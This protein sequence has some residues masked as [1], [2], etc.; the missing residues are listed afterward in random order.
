[1]PLVSRFLGI[2]IYFYY[3][4]HNPPHFHA[5]YG[6]FEAE[7]LI[8]DLSI[9]VGYLPPRVLGLVTEWASLHKTELLKN[10]EIG[11][12]GGVFNQIAPLT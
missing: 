5:V 4:E 11:R 1:M 7:I 2:I 6:E 10:W 12:M 8:E 3:R 9:D